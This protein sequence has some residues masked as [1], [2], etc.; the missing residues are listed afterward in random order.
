MIFDRLGIDT[1]EVL[2][3]AGSKWNFLPFRPGMVGGHCIGVDPYYLT[4][5]AEEVGY[6]PQVILAGRRINDEMARYAARSVVKKMLNNGIDVARARVAVL[7]VTFK[8]NCPDIRNSK[9]VDLIDELQNWSIETLVID[10]WASAAEVREHYSIALHDLAGDWQVDAVVV[11]VAHD[12]FKTLNLRELRARCRGVAPV[13][14]DLKAI[15]PAPML[16][17]LGFTVFRL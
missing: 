14:A 15:Y 8:D 17:E 9:V 16:R 4:H 13:I 10:P 11:A 2:E 3:A 12:E 6:N 5:K 1:I 7:G